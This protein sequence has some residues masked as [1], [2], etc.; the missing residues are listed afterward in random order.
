[1]R[2][3]S[4]SIRPSPQKW[5]RDSTERQIAARLPNAIDAAENARA[6]FVTRPKA[7][8][9]LPDVQKRLDPAAHS[10]RNFDFGPTDVFGQVALA[11]N[12]CPSN[13]IE[14]DQLQLRH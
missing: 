14:V 2:I 8:V 11:G 9:D 12:V 4:P 1:M 7:I 5:Q 10:C 6:D 3:V 13:F